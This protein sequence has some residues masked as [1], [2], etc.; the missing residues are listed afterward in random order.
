M[1][2]SKK[3][4]VLGTVVAVAG[5]AVF[6]NQPHDV[7]AASKEKTVT[8][9]LVGDSDRQLWE[10]VK[11]DAA[12]KYGI[13]I[14]LK[15]F[16]DYIKP[17]QALVDK[18]IDLN[19]FQTINYFDVQNK[20]FKGKLVSVGKTYVTP[21]RIYSDNH[22]TLADLPKG[23]TIVVP[24]DPSNEKRALDVL[25]AAGLIKYNHDVKL[26][27]AQDITENKK[28]FK[29]KE[30]AS[31]QAASALK[32]ADAAVVN[33]NYALDAKLDIDKA[34]YV[35]PVNKANKG[36]INIIAARKG[37]QN[38][39]IYKQ[40]VKAYQTESTKKH[41]KQLYGSAEIAAWDIKLK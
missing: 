28:D 30:V 3:Q 9:G 37:S 19:A 4:V 15:L 25:E 36:Y 17:N 1:G 20:N 21:I 2:I 6:A 32:S 39:K 16:T 24:N 7:S 13:D 22:K 35:E 27:S 26:P 10:Y 38:K 8:V 5:L 40:V 33:T 31:D 41:M 11:K 29:I 14:K 12:K 34:L 23:G 18:S